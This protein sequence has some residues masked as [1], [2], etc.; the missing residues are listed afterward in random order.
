MGNDNA[1]I[2]MLYYNY[3]KNSIKRQC[4]FTKKENK[5]YVTSQQRI[6]L[7]HKNGD[8]ILYGDSYTMDI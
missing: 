3:T 2:F 4:S 7:L 1:L 5:C 8:C 6:S